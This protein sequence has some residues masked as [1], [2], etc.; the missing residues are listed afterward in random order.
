MVE[1]TCGVVDGAVERMVRWQTPW[2]QHFVGETLGKGAR[3]RGCLLAVGEERQLGDDFSL[4][5]RRR[6]PSDKLSHCRLA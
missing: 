2:S 5:L 6:P 3:G 4:P 1:T